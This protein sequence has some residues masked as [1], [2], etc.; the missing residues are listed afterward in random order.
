M[1][2]MC[3]D[4]ISKQCGSNNSCMVTDLQYWEQ[5][6][7]ILLVYLSSILYLT[8]YLLRL[9]QFMFFFYFAQLI[10]TQFFWPNVLSNFYWLCLVL[11]LHCIVDCIF[12]Q[13]LLLPSN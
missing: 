9:L 10:V 1:E 13:H 7:N 6:N 12:G 8:L 4:T 5:S 11:R 2:W 3:F